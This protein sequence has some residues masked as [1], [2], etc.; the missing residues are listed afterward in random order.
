MFYIAA[1]KCYYLIKHID[2]SLSKIKIQFLLKTWRQHKRNKQRH[3]D[4]KYFKLK[5]I[6]RTLD[7]LITL[8]LSNFHFS[9]HI[10]IVIIYLHDHEINQIIHFVIPGYSPEKKHTFMWRGSYWQI[11]NSALVYFNWLCKH[12]EKTRRIRQ[13]FILTNVC[14]VLN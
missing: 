14:I 12:V 5:P 13:D 10:Q 3:S 8:F 4:N 11:L 1:L 9:F 6:L 7:L 2:T